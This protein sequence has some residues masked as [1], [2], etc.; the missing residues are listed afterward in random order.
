MKHRW[1]H[2]PDA[3]GWYET[4]DEQI[5]HYC[6]VRGWRDWTSAVGVEMNLLLIQSNFNGKLP[7][8]YHLYNLLTII[9]ERTIWISFVI[10]LSQT[11]DT[12]WEKTLC[13]YLYQCPPKC[14][15]SSV[16]IHHWYWGGTVSRTVTR[17]LTAHPNSECHSI[18]R[19]VCICGQARFE[20]QQRHWQWC[21][22][23]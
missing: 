10:F 15:V 18:I 16:S 17:N 13:I 8:I 1:K 19:R 7:S 9:P 6:H 3:E 2:E 14:L 4:H 22:D 20:Q 21:W 12:L 11:L 23:W 5:G